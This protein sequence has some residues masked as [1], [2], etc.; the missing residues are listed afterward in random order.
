MNIK[1]IYHIMPWEIDYMGLTF[2]N[3]KKTQLILRNIVKMKDIK[4]HI[5][6][7]LNLSSYIIDWDKS[8]LP[9]E[10]FIEK[11]NAFSLILREPGH[12]KW[13]LGKEGE[14]D[15]YICNHNKKIYEGD[16]LY[17]HLDLQK[18][19]IGEEFDYY[20]HLCPDLN[21]TENTLLSLIEGIF[22][23]KE[24]PNVHD[25][26]IITPSIPQMWDK[27][28]DSIVHPKFKNINFDDWWKID[29]HEI[30]IVDDIE[31]YNNGKTPKNFAF[32]A[33]QR[34]IKWAGWCDLYSKDLYENILKIPKEWKG[35]GS[36]DLLGMLI[37]SNLIRNNNLKFIQIVSDQII[38]KY[39]L[40]PLNTTDKP[41]NT[42]SWLQSPIKNHLHIKTNTKTKTDI[43]VGEYVEQRMHEIIND[44]SLRKKLKI[45]DKPWKNIFTEAN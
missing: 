16:E 17:G 13:G 32:N 22:Q 19:S 21:F 31:R 40:G 33:T 30:Q 11:Y 35:Y 27:S 45:T 4:F 23:I 39:S 5:D 6:S 15:E 9:K 44:K 34:V 20:I 24:Q 14:H 29:T 2:T 3:I 12:S 41:A 8:K 37:V 36:W 7:S 25:N 10:Y 28:W 18:D 43:M 42:G 38:S 1:I 26:F